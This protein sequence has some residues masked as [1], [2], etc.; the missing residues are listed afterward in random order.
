MNGCFR[1]T[2]RQKKRQCHCY[3]VKFVFIF[4]RVL[5]IIKI[6]FCM[7]FKKHFYDNV[8]LVGK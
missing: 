8:L 1:C 4:T 6:I 5:F 2:S 3:T 7:K